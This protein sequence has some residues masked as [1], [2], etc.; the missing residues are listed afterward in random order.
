MSRRVSRDKTGE[1]NQD[2]K[3]D[4]ISR[5]VSRDKAG[6]SIRDGRGGRCVNNYRM[7]EI[8]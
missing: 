3:K 4:F 1:S 2:G 6:E 5:R 7:S 8:T